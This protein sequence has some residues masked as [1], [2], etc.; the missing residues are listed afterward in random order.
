M[1]G[2]GH[3]GLETASRRLPTSYLLSKQDLTSAHSNPVIPH[4]EPINGNLGTRGQNELLG[5]RS[6][7]KPS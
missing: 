3:V 5:R 6:P 2:R 1:W 7:E 4:C